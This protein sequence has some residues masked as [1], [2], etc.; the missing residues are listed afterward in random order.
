MS[1]DNIS[2][3]FFQAAFENSP[4]GLVVMNG[5]T[6]LQSINNYMFATF[7]IDPR[8]FHERMLGNALKCSDIYLTGKNCGEG[9]HCNDCSLR[10]VLNASMMEGVHVP[11]TDVEHD[12]IIDG[13]N[14]KK[15][16][17]VNASR[18]AID[19]E[20]FIVMSF[21]DIT[22]QIEHEKLLNGQLSLDAAT[23]SVNKYALVNSLKNLATSKDRLAVAMI[24]LDNFKSV[25]DRYGHLAGDRVLSL[26]CSAAFTST[27]KQDIVGRFGGDE[28]MLIFPDT[29]T[30]FVIKALQRISTS[31]RTSCMNEFDFAPTFS[32]GVAEFST[33]NITGMSVD[34]IIT[35]ADENLY[36]SKKAGKNRVTASGINR[37]FKL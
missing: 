30:E 37:T 33:E 15:W 11:E 28:F 5:D 17:K 25:N 9:D 34:A 21:V 29:I 24:D 12:F 20:I 35:K 31:F 26:F 4:V 13:T 7:N 19:D 14:R 8:S 16:F 36:A 3:H 22:T 6:S 10:K 27:R 32:A 18:F 1:N 2:S 23:G